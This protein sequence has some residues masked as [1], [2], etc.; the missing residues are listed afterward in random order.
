M[1][2]LLDRLLDASIAG[3]PWE[4]AGEVNNGHIGDW[5]TERHTGQLA[6]NQTE[7]V[8][9]SNRHHNRSVVFRSVLHW[10]VQ[11]RNDFAHSLGS[12]S[13]SRDD[14]LVGAASIAPGLGRGAVHCL[15]CGGVGMDCGL[16]RGMENNLYDFSIFLKEVYNAQQGCMHLVN[17]YGKNSHS[18]CNLK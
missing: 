3:G 15:L 8:N 16:W 7:T 12:T 2:G 11:R 1:S 17:T 6:T 4:T 10:P 14:V 18:Y 9:F 13:G 5:H